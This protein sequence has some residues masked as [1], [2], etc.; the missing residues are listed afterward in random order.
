MD[1]FSLFKTQLKENGFSKKTIDSILKIANDTIYGLIWEDKK[2]INCMKNPY[3]KEIKEREIDC[4]ESNSPQHLLIEGDN[5][6]TLKLLQTTY[7][8]KINVIYIDPPYNTGKEFVYNDK[9]V[10]KEDGYRHSKWLSFMSKRLTLAKEL[11]SED[12]VM[13]ISIDDNE[14]AQLKLLCNDIFGELNV[15]TM[16]WHQ[17]STLKGAGSG[18]MKLTPRFRNE[19]EYIFVCYKDKKNTRFNK[20][21]TYSKTKNEYG[22]IDN[23]PRGNW[24]SGET[25]KSEAKSNPNGKNYYSVTTPSGSVYTR[26]WHFS[27]EEFNLLRLDGRIY[28]GKKGDSVP[29]LKKFINEKREIVQ[30]SI[31]NDVGNNTDGKSVLENIFGNKE[32]FSY[33][34]PTEL[35]IRLVS[36]HSNKNSII[37]DFFAG[38][39]TT[40]Q[41]VLELNKEDGGNRQFILCSNNENNICEEVT[42][43][44]LSR[45]INGYT[46]P[47]GKEVKGI[48]ANLKYLKITEQEN[49][50][51]EI[52]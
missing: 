7:R 38:S 16:I 36:L 41:A 21:Y 45:V 32:I 5:Y 3:L 8:G 24:I 30:S 23:D 39:G 37:L 15:E 12:G 40:G 33:P 35:I 34:K 25:C 47:K 46:T 51:N 48:S 1:K 28:F 6:E 52:E 10:D 29:R 31:I 26:Q 18:K 9:L 4:G 17:I 49:N 13:F 44:R 27:E 50:I 20:I 2:E 42:Y 22:N 43:K 19:H 14:M 11:M